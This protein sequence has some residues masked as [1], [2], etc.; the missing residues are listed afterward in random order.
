MVL[1]IEKVYKAYELLS[2]CKINK[3][4]DDDKLK[5]W[6]ILKTFKPVYEKLDEEVKMAAEMFKPY[7]D[8]EQRL[9][10]G[11]RYE[12]L[13]EKGDIEN[14]PMT[15]EEYN[16]FISDYVK[17]NELVGKAIEEYEKE[18]MTFDLECLSEESYGNL[19][20]SNDWDAQ[21]ILFLGE[22]LVS[23]EE[24]V[25]KATELVDTVGIETE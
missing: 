17:Y 18:K 9:E 19:I 6:K 25:R 14:L 11:K 10:D 2:V 8:Y 15:E 23:T 22:I 13:K 7:D 4:S 1:N 16:T 3:M 12:V 5:M 21:Q 24:A 20:A